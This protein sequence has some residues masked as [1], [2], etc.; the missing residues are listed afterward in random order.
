M[1]DWIWWLWRPLEDSEL[2]VMFEKQAGDD[3]SFA[4]CC[5][6][7]MRRWA[8]CRH[9]ETEML[10]N[11]ATFKLSSADTK[12]PPLQTADTGR[13]DRCR[14]DMSCVTRRLLV[15]LG[16]NEGLFDFQRIFSYFWT[17]IC[18]PQRR[19]CGKLPAVPVCHQQQPMSTCLNSWSCC[20]VIGW[21]NT[22][23]NRQFSRYNYKGSWVYNPHIYRI[24]NGQKT[25]CTYLTG[26]IIFKLHPHKLSKGCWN[27]TETNVCCKMIKNILLFLRF[28]PKSVKSGS[29]RLWL[30][31]FCLGIRF[32][33][34][35][36]SF[37]FV[38]RAFYSLSV[39]VGRLV[40]SPMC[41]GCFKV[42]L[43]AAFN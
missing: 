2:I 41:P 26:Q 20:H 37:V 36:F 22:C 28:G 19:L 16:W 33:C 34:F 18:E 4:A 24:W 32:F 15:N 7:A 25:F 21:Y 38:G 11:S 8:H 29:S 40:S 5:E 23:I 30:K 39:E 10:S 9:K 6:A 3:L 27:S 12:R 35:F 43:E 17:I 13:I 14:F 42:E 31:C 1:L